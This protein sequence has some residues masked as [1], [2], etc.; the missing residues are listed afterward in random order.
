MYHLWQSGLKSLL[1]VV[2]AVCANSVGLAQQATASRIL[3]N[4]LRIEILANPQ[5]Q[6]VAIHLLIGV[7][8]TLDPAGK[9]GLAE[10]AAALVLDSV[11]EWR[12]D[13]AE[14]AK[15]VEAGKTFRYEVTWDSTHFFTECAPQELGTYFQALER[16]VKNPSMTEARFPS[17]RDRV[18]ERVQ[19][20]PAG[21]KEIAETLFDAE[22]FAGNPYA[23]PMLGVPATL[24]N[25]IYGDAVLFQRRYYL[26]N[27]SFLGLVGPVDADQVK[28]T[29]GRS[30]GVWVM[31]EQFPFTF[32][33]AKGPTGLTL[34][35]LDRPQAGEPALIVGHLGV[36]RDSPDFTALTLLTGILR[37]RLRHS[38]GAVASAGREPLVA[39]DGR[40]LRGAIRVTAQGKD[41]KVDTA[42]RELRQAW[43]D[44][45]EKGPTADET[46]AAVAE[47]LGGLQAQASTSAGLAR[48]LAE[49]GTYQLGFNYYERLK[50]EVPS[51]RAEDLAR[52]A[53][54]LFDA[55]KV[56]AVFVG[57]QAA[58][59]LDGLK[60][61]GWQLRIIPA[62]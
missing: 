50:R 51:L 59:N 17:V 25:I 44:L 6:R 26:P 35:A 15:I 24:K 58:Q 46:S 19:A 53:Q 18:L 5:S 2:V 21:E 23:R 48:M 55:E 3:L 49:A 37:N 54:R 61:E 62:N 10:L 31:D 41:L 42:L 27:V 38:S 30:L 28:I 8:T 39:A 56:L 20:G 11:P 13:P 29:A 36:T 34:V 4:G 12:G 16:L 14:I 9:A 60:P 52:V 1:L 22:L 7:G 43:S 57:P 45:H 32:L 40:R 47:F 33:P